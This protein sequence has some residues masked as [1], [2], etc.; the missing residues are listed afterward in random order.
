M[1][2]ISIISGRLTLAVLAAALAACSELMPA[3]PD[4]ALA[5]TPP[6]RQYQT[7]DLAVRVAVPRLTPAPVATR[8]VHAAGPAAA[9]VMPGAAADG[10]DLRHEPQRYAPGRLASA[11]GS[12][13]DVKSVTITAAGNDANGVRQDSLAEAELTKSEGSWVGTLAGITLETPIDFTAE[14]KDASDT[15]LFRGTHT[16]TLT[17]RTAALT[18]NLS[19]VSG[20]DAGQFP[21]VSAITVETIRAQGSGNV[22]VSVTGK[23][24]ETLKYEFKNGTFSPSSGSVTTDSPQSGAVG[25]AAIT[26]K[27]TAPRAKGKYTAQVVVTNSAGNRVAVDFRIPVDDPARL[28]ANLGPAV[29]SVAGRRIPAG[30]QWSAKVS[31]AGDTAVTYSWSFTSAPNTPVAGTSFSSATT[32]PTLLTGYDQTKTGTLKVTATQGTLSSSASFQVPAN[33]FPNGLQLPAAELVIN[34]IDYDTEGG[35]DTAEFV[36][37]LNPGSSAVDLSGYRIELVDGARGAAY[38]T[39]T[40]SGQ[41]GAGKYFVIGDTAVIQPDPPLPAGTI[42]LALDTN[43]QQGPDIVRIVKIST[44]KVMD[45]VQYEGSA[46]GAGEGAPAPSDTED[47][48]I[49]RCPNGSD[50]NDNGADFVTMPPTPGKT[51][52]CS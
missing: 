14:A 13:A 3:A 44:K 36:E 38:A 33:L 11:V 43:L 8:S 46:N 40:G 48:S 28:A 26:S 35:S 49:G 19:A 4:S 18:I 52:T 12:H 24:A 39:Y 47:K 7:T 51:N 15:V 20:A 5:S 41:L 2:R 21:V 50:T 17:R 27:Y 1:Y 9:V 16:A 29:L 22:T 31:S 30:V 6:A 45:A 23:K 10:I 32:N 34:E 42:T 25:T 37:I